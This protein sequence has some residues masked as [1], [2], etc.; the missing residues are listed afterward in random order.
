MILLFSRAVM[1]KQIKNATFSLLPARC[2]S[3]GILRQCESSRYSAWPYHFENELVLGWQPLAL[4]PLAPMRA[5]SHWSHIMT[6][7]LTNCSWV[8]QILDGCL[9]NS[10]NKCRVHGSSPRFWLLKH[11]RRPPKG[12][13]IEGQLLTTLKFEG[14]AKCSI[15]PRAVEH[16]LILFSR[17]S[18]IVLWYRYSHKLCCTSE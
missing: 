14:N 3:I 9:S 8:R 6:P 7:V 2:A 17:H 5:T 13:R 10:T 1:H 4:A 11:P 18:T 15:I 16:C 12:A